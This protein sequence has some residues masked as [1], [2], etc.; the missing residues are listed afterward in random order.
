M[1]NLR[2]ISNQIFGD[3]KVIE[4]DNTKGKYKYYWICECIH[5]GERKSIVTSSLLNGKSI[6]CNKCN[7]DYNK[8]INIKGYAKD[9]TGNTYGD[10]TVLRYSHKEHSHSFWEC[11]CKCGKII[12]C[13]ISYL[14]QSEYKMCQ[15]CRL[16]YMKS[17]RTPIVKKIDQKEVNH[18]GFR[19]KY[20]KY[21]F[22]DDIVIINDNILIDR[23]DFEKVDAM[24]KYVATNSSGYALMWE[25]IKEC[26]LHRFLMGLSLKYDPETQLIVDHINGNSLDNR[27]SN[28]RIL[29]KEYNPINCKTYSN[30]TSGVKGLSWNKKLN[31]WSVS[32]QVNKKSIYLGVYADKN[33]AIKVRKSAEDKYFGE[34]NR[35]EED[36]YD[37]QQLS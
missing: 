5:C 17:I 31:K 2:D 16:E 1:G 9:L 6:K 21:E 26:F 33:E 3:W 13:S 37:L 4:F 34:L 8:P 14:N 19:K 23:D 29:K 10:L 25:G 22:K 28:L 20:N 35:K 32:I 11:E 30:N 27:K 7:A 12:T 18:K 15:T 24:N 36:T